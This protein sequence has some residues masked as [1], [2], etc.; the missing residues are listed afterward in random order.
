MYCRISMQDFFLTFIPARFGVNEMVHNP[1]R[2]LFRLGFSPR[3]ENK[4]G[5]KSKASSRAKSFEKG[6]KGN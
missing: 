3:E 4:T 2:H 5:G 6:T 1:L